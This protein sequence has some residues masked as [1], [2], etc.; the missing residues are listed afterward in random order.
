MPR[1]GFAKM[2]PDQQFSI[3]WL[4]APSDISEQPMSEEETLTGALN[5]AENASKLKDGD[6]WVGIEGGCCDKNGEMEAFAWIVIKSRSGKIS[7]GRT[8]TVFLPEK[9]AA[10]IRSGKELGEADD[11]V[12]QDTNSK[13][14]MGTVGKLTDNAVDRTSYNIDAVVFALIPFKNPTLY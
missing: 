9:I 1:L 13:Q 14:K 7:K 8:G 4:S 6:Y 11:I 5:R 10:L 2:F 3:E 12:F